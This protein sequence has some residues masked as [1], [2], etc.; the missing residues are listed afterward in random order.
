MKRLFPFLIIASIILTS[1]GQSSSLWGTY[2]TPTPEIIYPSPFT[3]DPPTATDTAT[4]PPL[5]TSTFTLTPTKIAPTS[6]TPQTPSN[7][8]PGLE[9]TLTPKSDVPSIL[10]YS[11]SGDTLPALAARFN[12]NPSEIQSDASLPEQAMIP[13]GTLLVIPDRITE[14]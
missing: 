2:S 5:P 1:C 3:P 8:T 6:S 13:S 12:V 9:A 7:K 10:Y 4:L 11:Q 14:K